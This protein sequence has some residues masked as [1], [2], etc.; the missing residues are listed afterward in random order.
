M[1]T[2]QGFNESIFA[3]ARNI[4]NYLDKISL[5]SQGTR[6]NATLYLRKFESYL[7]E[8]YSKSNEDVLQ[9]ILRF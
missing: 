5:K 8:T 3:K 9:E 6:D 2:S 7:Q 1:K 4:T